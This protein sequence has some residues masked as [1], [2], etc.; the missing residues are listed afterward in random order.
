[1]ERP[2]PAPTPSSLVVKN[3]SEARRIV[4]RCR[5]SDHDAALYDASTQPVLY[6]CYPRHA[7]RHL[8]R[9]AEGRGDRHQERL[10]PTALVE[11]EG[12]AAP[13]LRGRRRWPS[14]VSDSA[15]SVDL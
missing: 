14:W 13:I 4:S 9:S 3:G 1:M 7:S 2:N 15:C 5:R 8:A 12:M 10:W 11:T 6:R